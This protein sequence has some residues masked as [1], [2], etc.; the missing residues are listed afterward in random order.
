MH[1]IGYDTSTLPVYLYS[2]ISSRRTNEPL[3]L[4]IA[5]DPGDL[6]MAKVTP[7]PCTAFE[8]ILLYT[9]ALKLETRRFST[10]RISRACATRVDTA[11]VMQRLFISACTSL[12][13]TCVYREGN[14]QFSI[15][16]QS[17]AAVCGWCEVVRYSET[18]SAAF[19]WSFNRCTPKSD[20]KVYKNVK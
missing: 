6:E 17:D 3:M 14:R 5:Q 15:E 9:Y 19:L 2:S 18:S 12:T 13:C 11:R 10:T 8:V 1:L 7:T 16:M 4:G 20:V